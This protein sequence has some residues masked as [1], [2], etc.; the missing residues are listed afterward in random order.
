M[1]L[2]PLLSAPV[3]IQ[4]HVLSA[5]LAIFLGPMTLFRKSRDRWHKRL[6]YLWV[7]A[8][9]ST[10]A[11]SFAILES[12]MIGPFSVIHGLSVLTFWGLWVGIAAVRR[13]DIA[14]HQ[15]QMKSLYFWALGVAGLFTFAP[16]RRM[17]RI[18]FGDNPD[19]GFAIAAGV[20]GSLLAW[21]VV[22]S[23]PART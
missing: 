18:F 13:G 19:V 12:P 3:E 2:A 10:A 11:T 7:T 8:M 21:Y 5:L 16:G 22:Q 23:R 20:I 17:N 6:G 15:A 4:L 9:F 14:R 1:T